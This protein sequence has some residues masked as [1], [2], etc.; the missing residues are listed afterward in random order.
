MAILDLHDMPFNHMYDM[1]RF[2]YTTDLILTDKNVGD[3]LES[4]MRLDLQVIVDMCIE[5]LQ[6]YT[7]QTAI[8]YFTICH[9]CQ[10]TMLASE[11]WHYICQNFQVLFGEL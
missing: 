8:L 10:V 7:L 11:I 3:I 4:S 1:V 6:H 9:Q 2:L 5:Y